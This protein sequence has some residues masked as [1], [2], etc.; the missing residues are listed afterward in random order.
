MIASTGQI[1]TQSTNA[2]GQL[3]KLKD[4]LSTLNDRFTLLQT[5][6][7]KQFATM[8]SFVGQT[9][10]LKTSLQSSFAGMMSMYT[11]KN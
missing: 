9:N 1:N 8:D 11:N 10:S 2:N 6:Y 5:R 7:A 4:K 3:T